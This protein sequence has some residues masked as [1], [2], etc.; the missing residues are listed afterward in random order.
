ME[1]LGSLIDKLT[2][3]ELKIIHSQNIP[4]TTLMEQKT[5]LCKEID[6]FVAGA[7][8][9]KIDAC[10]LTFESNKVYDETIRLPDLKGDI[11]ELVASLGAINCDIWH[12]VDQSYHADVLERGELIKLVNDL[13]IMNLHRNKCIDNINGAFKEMVV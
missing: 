9:G 6:T 10:D 7:I 8:S 2:V 12:K 1:T 4:A 5:K 13:A 11:G 3:V